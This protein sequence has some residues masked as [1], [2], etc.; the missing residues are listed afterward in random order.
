[1][2]IPNSQLPL[3]GELAVIFLLGL[4][5][6]ADPKLLASNKKGSKERECSAEYSPK[7]E[8]SSLSV[9]RTQPSQN[10]D[11][12]NNKRNQPGSPPECAFCCSFRNR[13]LCLGV[14]FP[15]RQYSLDTLLNSGNLQEHT[16]IRNLI[17]FSV[18]V[19][20]FCWL[21]EIFICHNVPPTTDEALYRYE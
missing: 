2:L 20:H 4:A 21:C 16:N 8:R 12:Y 15:K 10:R 5:R 7:E 13:Q 17:R 3:W 6:A 19:G 1:M 14:H 18:C 11:R 9:K